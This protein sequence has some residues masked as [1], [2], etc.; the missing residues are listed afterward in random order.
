MRVGFI[1]ANS[2]GVYDV[3]ENYDYHWWYQTNENN[4]EWADKLASLSSSR[5]TGSSGVNPVSLTWKNGDLVYNSAG[6]FYQIKDSRTVN[7]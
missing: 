7:W 6:K 2:N 5:K 1:D 4:G 3:H